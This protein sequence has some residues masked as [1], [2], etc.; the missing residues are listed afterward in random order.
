[1]WLKK[2]G[3]G[4]TENPQAKEHKFIVVVVCKREATLLLNAIENKTQQSRRQRKEN[5]NT[6]NHQ[7]T[8]KQGGKYL[9]G[10]ERT[11]LVCADLALL[12]QQ[13][14]CQSVENNGAPGGG[15]GGGGQTNSTNGQQ[16]HT[17]T[18]HASRPACY[19]D[20]VHMYEK[21]KSAIPM[22][23]SDR[24]LGRTGN[25]QKKKSKFAP[26]QP[27]WLTLVSS[28]VAP[29]SFCHVIDVSRSLAP[30]AL[31]STHTNSG[32]LVFT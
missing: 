19:D 15:R 22:L 30:P 9:R 11:L 1:M 3:Q 7:H 2:L 13:G 29:P 20:K 16:T 10:R 6:S 18:T 25:P 8:W 23:L 5:A 21:I 26:R 27:A 28:G 31:P 4:T 17:N 12:K 24:D 32:H 14:C